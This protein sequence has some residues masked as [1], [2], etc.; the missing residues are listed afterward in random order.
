M[1]GNLVPL[2]GAA[3]R[4]RLPDGTL[5]TQ[6]TLTVPHDTTANPE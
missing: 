2:P 3:T 5:Q 4:A 6:A 1:A